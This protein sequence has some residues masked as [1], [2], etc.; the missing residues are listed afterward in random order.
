MR[1]PYNPAQRESSDQGGSTRHS[2][3]YVQEGIAVSTIATAS[4]FIPCDIPNPVNVQITPVLEGRSTSDITN[5]VCLFTTVVG[6]Y[7]SA[8]RNESLSP[9]A[10]VDDWV[11][12]EV[13]KIGNVRLDPDDLVAYICIIDHTASATNTQ[14]GFLADVALGYW[15]RLPA[16]TKFIKI[17]HTAPAAGDWCQFNYRITGYRD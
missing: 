15:Q 1:Q 11:A 3:P 13:I 17:I 10:D 14:A 9:I 16:A 4:T 8:L 2:I 7:V 6:W 12:S 5:G